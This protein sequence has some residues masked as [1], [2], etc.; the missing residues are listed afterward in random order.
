MRFSSELRSHRHGVLVAG[1]WVTALENEVERQLARGD[2]GI[3]DELTHQ[4]ER[5]LIQKALAHTGGRRIEAAT[6]LGWGRN[7]LT[8]KIQELG[9]DSPLQGVGSITTSQ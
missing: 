7:T 9:M 2:V 4:F 6:L 1:D 3:I 5:A 8:R